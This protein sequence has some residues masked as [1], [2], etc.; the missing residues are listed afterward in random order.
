LSFRRK[1]TNALLDKRD[2]RDVAKAALVD[3]LRNDKWDVT[4]ETWQKRR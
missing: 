2:E 1:S 4:S 3:F